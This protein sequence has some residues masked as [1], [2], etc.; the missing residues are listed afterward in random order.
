[1]N[2]GISRGAYSRLKYFLLFGG[3]VDNY[4]DQAQYI[5]WQWSFCVTAIILF[6]FLI[7]CGIIFRSKSNLHNSSFIIVISISR[8]CQRMGRTLLSREVSMPGE[9]RQ[10]TA[11]AAYMMTA[12]QNSWWIDTIQHTATPYHMS[13]SVHTPSYHAKTLQ[14]QLLFIMSER[15]EMWKSVMSRANQMGFSES[16]SVYPAPEEKLT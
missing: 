13:L 16:T 15:E 9:P 5:Q 1:M 10:L 11:S 4:Q 7:S 8:W 14:Q 12:D 2:F 6:H 3:V